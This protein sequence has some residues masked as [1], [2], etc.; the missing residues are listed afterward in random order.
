[1]SSVVEPV[2]ETQ[3]VLEQLEA[4]GGEGTRARLLDVGQP[5][6]IGPECVGL[7]LGVLADGPTFT[8]VATSDEIASLDAV[9]YLDGGPCIVGAHGDAGSKPNLGSVPRIGPSAT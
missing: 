6:A 9:Q 5:R 8:L 7:G 2:L 1:L 3:E 4:F